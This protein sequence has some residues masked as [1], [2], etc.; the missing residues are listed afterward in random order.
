MKK[1]IFTILALLASGTAYALPVG[2]P[3]DASL[4]CDGLFVEGHCGDPCDP[5]LTWLDAFSVR[6]GFYGDYVFNRHMEVD[7]NARDCGVEH[8]RINTNAAFLAVNFWDRF[9][10]FS[11]LGVT[12][13]FV[14]TNERAFGLADSGRFKIKTNSSFS[15]SLGVRG[16]IWECGCTTLGA[17]AQY[18]YTRPDIVRLTQEDTLSIYPKGFS[19]KYREWQIGI[20]IAH[21]INMLVPYAAV[22]LGH[23]QFRL[24]DTLVSG[25]FND[26]DLATAILFD[27][28]SKKLWG[29][30]IGVSF[31]DCDKASLTVEGRW[32]N[33]K[34]LY[35]NGQIRF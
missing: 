26:D 29:Y 20:G 16:T 10:I 28:E 32:G 19:A 34:A 9:D 18:F 22:K 12:N 30:A 4:V 33:E 21:R 14:E 8:M 1:C 35:V 27:L 15:W 3:A 31:I 7:D 6:V 11:I 23:A 25:F 17:E 2:N 13:I 5:C 24:D